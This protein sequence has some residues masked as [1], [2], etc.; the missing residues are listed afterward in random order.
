MSFAQWYSFYRNKGYNNN[1]AN[2][3][4]RAAG[5]RLRNTRYRGGAS[6]NVDNIG[7]TERTQAGYRWRFPSGRVM[8]YKTKITRP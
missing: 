8:T 5:V 7:R 1:Q 6:M 2:G 3:K 4:A